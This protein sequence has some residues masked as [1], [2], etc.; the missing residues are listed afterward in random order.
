MSLH[1][2]H[3]RP[4]HYIHYLNYTAKE[5]LVGF[6]VLAALLLILGWLIAVG[7]SSYLFEEKV[8]FFAHLKNAQGVSI[9]GQVKVS[10]IEVG[11][12]SSLDVTPG[13]QI[14][15]GFFVYEKFH[16]LVR[17]DSRGALSKLGLIGSAVLEITAGDPALPLLEPGAWLEIEEPQT[18]D[19]IIADL[20]PVLEN[21]KRTFAAITEVTNAISGSDV[22]QATENFVLATKNIHLLT[23]RLLGTD[24][25]AGKLINSE[26]FSQRAD[27]A[28]GR[29][30]MILL[31]IDQL[32]KSLEPILQDVA[33][34]AANSARITQE[35]RPLVGKIEQLLGDST[36]L[37]QELQNAVPQLREDLHLV[38]VNADKSLRLLNAELYRLPD[39]MLQLQQI[40]ETT[41]RTLEGLQQTWPVSGAFPKSSTDR[42]IKV[43]PGAK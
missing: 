17:S 10:G 32:V 11:R 31:R 26:E 25:V 33:T 22:E 5:R 37:T 8:H 14:K 36:I 42:L 40:L 24:T 39:M 6:F 12:V 16:G 23:E 13:N 4:L 38:L 43:Y 1:S 41:G 29:G 35:S 3:N 34:V 28:F 18:I 15:I 21:A 7:D 9:D 19:Q 30:E 2:Q 20:T 27:R